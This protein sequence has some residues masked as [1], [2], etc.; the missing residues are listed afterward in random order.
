MYK[1]LSIDGAL[2]AGGNWYNDI[3]CF[4]TIK[5]GSGQPK[6]WINNSTQSH[7]AASGLGD[8][9]IGYQFKN[10]NNLFEPY[11]RL[12][13]QLEK[14][15]EYET[16]HGLLHIYVMK[17]TSQILRLEGGF[18]GN[19][20]IKDY[21]SFGEDILLSYSL[22]YMQV[23]PSRN[24]QVLYGGFYNWPGR[25]LS[26]GL[27]MDDKIVRVGLGIS[28]INK[29]AINE[30]ELNTSFNLNVEKSNRGVDV[31]L[32]LKFRIRLYKIT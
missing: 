1:G 9:K 16:E 25:F 27:P 18:W 10:K 23:K 5:G 13:Y 30:S 14:E 8:L 15:G 2:S 11:V 21:P 4:C 7:E 26:E 19:Y 31:G 32:F 3:S 17:H 20:S 12:S 22:S 28:K 29:A 6:K 24:A